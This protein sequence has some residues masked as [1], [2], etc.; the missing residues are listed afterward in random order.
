VLLDIVEEAALEGF[1]TLSMKARKE[2][3]LIEDRLASRIKRRVRERTDKRTIVEV[4]VHKVK[5]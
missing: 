1:E 4:I 2:E 3:D 5:A